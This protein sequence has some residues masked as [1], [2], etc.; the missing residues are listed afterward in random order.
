[1]DKIGASPNHVSGIAELAQLAV[2]SRADVKHLRVWNLVGGD[3]A[4]AE[5]CAAIK[6]L[7]PAKLIPSKVA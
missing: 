2:Y 6:C 1:M 5:W 3:D 7:S 4:R